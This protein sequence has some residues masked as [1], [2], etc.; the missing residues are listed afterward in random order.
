METMMDHL[1]IIPK[2][3]VFRCN[4]CTKELTVAKKAK[5]RYCKSCVKHYQNIR[6][7]FIKC[8][9]LLYRYK[10]KIR[11]LVIHKLN[12]CAKNYIHEDT[13]LGDDSLENIKNLE[14]AFKI[15]Q[16]QMKEGDIA[17]IIM[18]NFIGWE[19][20]GNKS[21][22]GLDIRKLD[23]SI[24]MEIKNKY[25]TCNS[26]SQKAVL[27]KL[28]N[29]KRKFPNTRCVWGIVNPKHGKS[30]HTIINYNGVDVEKIQGS[31]LLSLVFTLH[32]IDY[33]N[34]IIKYTKC[35]MY[36]EC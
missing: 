2:T 22:Y 27:D 31:L 10:K 13:I 1:V 16:K 35:I 15:R 33:S 32:G 12:R 26:G 29:Y 24:I 34:H 7:N 3:H 4:R 23:N 11:N 14:I 36:Q 20:L 6:N 21:K 8:V 17:Q 9:I 25:N 5:E 28:S 30:S 19:D 18:G